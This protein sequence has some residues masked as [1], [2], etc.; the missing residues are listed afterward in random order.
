MNRTNLRMLISIVIVFLLPTSALALNVSSDNATGAPNDAITLNINIDSAVTNLDAWGF[1]LYY[2][3]DVLTYASVDK[4][5]TICENF[6]LVNGSVKATGPVAYVRIGGSDFSGGVTTTSGGVLIKVNF[7]VNADAASNSPIALQAFVD[8]IAAAQ[9]TDAT[10]SLSGLPTGTITLTPSPASITADGTSTSTITSAAIKD[11]ASDNVPDGTK[12]TVA[13]NLGTITTA[14]ADPSGTAGTQVETS[15]GVITFTLQS[16]TTAGTATVTAASVAGDATGNTTVD[17]TAGVVSAANSTVEVDKATTPVGVGDGEGITVTVT[18]KDAN[19]NPVANTDVTLSITGSGNYINGATEGNGPTSIGSTNA[20]GVATGFIRS[21]KAEGKIISAAGGGTAITDTEA[22]TYTQGDATRLAVTGITDPVTAGVASD[23]IVT[24]YDQY[25]NIATGYVGTIAFTAPGDPQPVLHA[26]YTF[27]AGDN[28]TKTFVGGVTL[29]TAGEQAVTATDTANAGITGSQT[30]ITVN[31]AAANTLLVENISDPITAGT[32]SDVKVT[33]YDEFNNVATGYTGTVAFTS[34]D[35][36]KVVPAD[37]TFL[38]GDNGAKTFAGGVTLKTVGEQTV[39]ATDT[40]TGT[41]TG[42]QSAITVNP[43]AASTLT[44]TGIT[45]PVVAGVASDVIVTAKD[46]FGNTATGYTG[47]VAFTSGDTNATLPGNYP[48]VGGDSGTKTFASGV[49][50]KTAGEQTVTATDATTGT[51]TGTQSAITVNAANVSKVGLIATKTTLASDQKGSATLTATLYDEFDN[52]VAN[53]GTTINLIISSNTYV[54]IDDASPTTNA[55]GVATATIT[56][57]TGD[58]TDP[59]QYTNV[60]AESTGLT[61]SGDI[62]FTLVNF[63]INVDSPAA[64]FVDGTGVHLVTSG[65]TPTTAAFSGVGGTDGNYRWN[66]ASVGAIDSTTADTVNYT[67]PASISLGE[68]E[69]FKKDTLTLTD[70]ND[71][72][73]L[74]DTIDIYIYNPLAVT[75]PTSEAGIAI[76]DTTKGVTVTGGTGTYKFQSNDTAV[77]TVDADGGGVTPVAVGTCNIQVRDA[78]YGVFGTENGFYAVSPQIEIVDP[79]SVTPATKSLEAS[80]TQTFAAT[81]GKAGGYTWTCDNADAGAIDAE[82]GV[83][84]AAA[85][86]ATQ[87][88]TITATDGYDIEGTA[89]VTVYATVEI[90]NKPTET[91]TIESG[92]TSTTYTVEGGDDTLYTWSVTGPVAVTGGT[93]ASYAFV[94]PSTGAFA[95]VYTI[96]VTDNAGF[97]DSFEVNVPIKLTP[98]SKAFTETKLDGSANPQTLTLSGADGDY[99]WEILD[100]ETATSEVDAPA[101]Y[102]TWSA[103]G[104]AIEIFTPAD[105]DAVKKFYVRVTVESDAALTEDNGLNKRVFGPFN[106][107]PVDTFTVT[108]SDSDETAIAGANVSVDYIDPNTSTPIAAEITDVDGEAVF[109]LPDA[110]GTYSYTV[111]ATNKVRQEVSSASKEVTVTLEA[112]GDTITGTVEDT[113]GAVKGGATVTAYQPSDVT[114]KYQATTAGDGTY[115]INLPNGAAESGWTVVASLTNFV[116]VSQA[117]QAVDTAVNFT[118]A[119]GLQAKTTIETV[120]AVVVG[121]TVR[122]DITASPAFAAVGEASVSLIEGD[123]TLGALSFAGGTVSVV[124][125]MVEDFTVVIKA[126]TSEDKDPTTGYYASRVFSYVAG[127][128]AT[129]TAQ[130][131]VAAVSSGD[132]KVTANSQTTEVEV[133]VGGLTKDATIVIKQIPKDDT[134]STSTK[135]SLTYV[136]EVTAADSATGTELTSDEINRVEITLPIDLSVVSP[137]DL[138]D[139]VFVIYHADSLAELEAGSGTA[140]PASDIISTDYIG[141]GSIGSVTFYVSSLSVFGIGGSSGGG[142]GDDDNCFIAT[143]A[144]GSLFE[145]HVEILRDFRDVYLL[146]SRLGHAFVDTYYKYSPPIAGFIAD[147]DALRAVVRVGL[148]PAVGA[149][150]VAL[151]TTPAQKILIMF[152]MFGLFAGGY[153]AIRRCS[154]R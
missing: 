76:G 113:L 153:L 67:A 138:E 70:L 131:D 64:L 40:T 72:D 39:T 14:D 117:D 41:I 92:A 28:G 38:T 146:P 114:T 112:I 10:F 110:G 77:A 120:E 144:Y 11:A 69:T 44:V 143:A 50:L 83:F 79:I 47:T 135:A 80:G 154:G 130:V 91:P 128:T 29:K 30:D 58:V 7:T 126:D 31:P 48:F 93:G 104:T 19:D 35:D 27:Q 140:V 147:H 105:V 81:G 12:I 99:T 59:P 21:T 87:T 55:Q 139:G 68:G 60:H 71:P 53:A 6:S 129:A 148:M 63:S 97:T 102:G 133:P 100:S 78:T 116:T 124:Y 45:D 16:A 111:T 36:Q 49:T 75:W 90:T 43:A 9:T 34:S 74:T 141:N 42:T 37:Y 137:G 32:A 73:N 52:Q 82:T 22:V 107:I 123:G 3:G 8:D 84:T 13:T 61:N 127:D 85:V 17:F 57:K 18:L 62:L 151:H 51:I 101:D 46:E 125:D 23:V 118:G 2:N 26:D 136:Y 24:A 5:D 94:A 98:D 134:T 33:A 54:V 122:L 65:S 1:D 121:A 95:G 152:L 142:G 149:S 115:T 106:I 20:S 145:S 15:S 88:A 150:Y 66:L 86:T 96:T 89:T 4:T 25:D 109:T 132:G 103:S 56:T 108:V 119:Y